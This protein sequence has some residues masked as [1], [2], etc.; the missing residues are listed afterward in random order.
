[1]IRFGTVL[2]TNI[3][4]VIIESNKGEL[5][6]TSNLTNVSLQSLSV[7]PKEAIDAW[8]VPTSTLTQGY[9]KIMLLMIVFALISILTAIG[10][11]TVFSRLLTRPLIRLS[12]A[13]VEVGAGNL[14]TR[15]PVEKQDEFSQLGTTFNEMVD[16]IQDLVYRVED[17]AKKQRLLELRLLYSQIKPHFLYNTLET[18]RFYLYDFFAGIDYRINLSKPAG[19]RIV[20]VMFQGRPLA[21]TDELQLAVNN[22]R[23]SSLLKASKLVKATKHWESPCSIRDCLLDYVRERHTLTPEVDNNWS[24]IGI[25]LS[26][27]YRDEVIRLVNEGKLDSPYDKSLNVKELLEAGWIS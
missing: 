3:D 19:E 15:A 24:I 9:W 25:D 20:N 7:Y 27:P 11:P 13:I 23:Y 12:K 21:D 4:S 8:L 1:M 14:N 18:I 6:Y 2:H 10:L 26:S 5:Y 16:R 17:E 22:Y